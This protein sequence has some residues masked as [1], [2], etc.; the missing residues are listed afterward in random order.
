M[1][2]FRADLRGAD[3]DGG[4][5]A[6]IHGPPGTGKTQTLLEL[7]LQLVT[8]PPS[9]SPSADPPR[10]KKVLVCGPSNISVDNIVL[11]LPSS[12]PIIRVGHP[13]RLLPRVIE[14]SLDALTRTSE[15]GEIVSDVRKEMD[16][17][18]GR[19]NVA[20]KA[21]LKGK[22]RRDG[23]TQV[24]DLRGEYRRREQKCIDELV[25]GSKVVLATLHGAGGRQLQ[26]EHF[27][28]VI[29]DEAS[30]ALEA[31]C[32]IPLLLARGGIQK[33]VIAGDPMQ[34][35]PTIK[36]ATTP[37]TTT[38]LSAAEATLETTLFSRLLALHGAGVKRVLTTQYRMHERIMAF[39]SR[40][41]Y[42][43]VLV[44]APS[45]AS[46]LLTTLPYPVAETEATT[47]PLLFIDTQGG[48]FPEDPA[49][50]PAVSKS[51]LGSESKSNE[52]EARLVALH[53][54]GLI[55]AGVRESDIAVLT[56]YNAQ[57]AQIV[58]LVRP[59]HGGVEVNSVDSFQG[60]E[61]E[62]VVISLVRS[63]EKRETGFLKDV[64]RINVAVTRAR[65]HLCV[66]GDSDTVA[67]E[68]GFL[69]RWIEW[70]AD[71]A[72]S[73]AV[74]RYPDVAEV[75]SGWVGAAEKGGRGV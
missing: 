60:R 18:L 50:D 21:R 75:L 17:L 57:V 34:L 41:L 64:R 40:E 15:Q 11:R 28:V 59:R 3:A 53:V 38:I 12:L 43:S 54:E 66:V 49:A 47:A 71:E 26:S 37:Q 48:E 52:L 14:R 4:A 2:V 19:L 73:G 55:A 31:Q 36:S 63:N 8:P 16:S 65:R 23:W 1:G 67:G 62:A 69:K 29:I 9:S 42:D 61:K 7:I 20:G 39:P 44:A 74:V 46:H 27:D 56:P 70:L 58:G 33:L 32:W 10:P 13:A 30:Q 24:R 25:H 5:A 51:A 45:V 22:A 68:R 35:P 72:E 6:L